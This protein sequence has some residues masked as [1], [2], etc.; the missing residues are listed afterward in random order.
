MPSGLS[1]RFLLTGSRAKP[2]TYPDRVSVYHRLR[3]L[4]LAS[5]SSLILD[6]IILS[7]KHRRVAAQTEEELVIYDYGAARKTT[8]PPFALDVFTDTW[9]RQEAEVKRSRERIWA[10]V[11]EVEG[12]ENETWNKEGAV[13]DLGSAKTK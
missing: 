11:G 10:L 13:E 2:M 7:H 8:V 3:T 4:P 6:C 5:D 12:L 1:F 9:R